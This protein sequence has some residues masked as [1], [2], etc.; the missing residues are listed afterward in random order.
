M[1]VV[2]A[3]DRGSEGV[4]RENLATPGGQFRFRAVGER[5]AKAGGGPAFAPK[6]EIAAGMEGDQHY[7]I[8][9][10]ICNCCE[11]PAETSAVNSAVRRTP[12]T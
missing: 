5:G 12:P 3:G 10:R 9:V 2:A 7:W 4:R 1:H 8:P 11:R 6:F